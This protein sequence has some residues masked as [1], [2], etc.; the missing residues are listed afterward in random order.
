MHGNVS[1]NGKKPISVF[2]NPMENVALPALKRN[3]Y[4]VTQHSLAM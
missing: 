4:T 3:A 2:E 1:C